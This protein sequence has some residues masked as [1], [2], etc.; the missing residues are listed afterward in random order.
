MSKHLRGNGLVA[1][2]LLIAFMAE[3]LA[4]RG[5][6]YIDLNSLPVPKSVQLTNRIVSL[7][8]VLGCYLSDDDLAPL[9]DVL[10]NEYQMLAG[11][12]ATVVETPA[13]AA[14]I[15]EIDPSLAEQEYRLELA[16]PVRI[17]GG[18]YLGVAM[19]SVTLMQSL[20]SD[21]DESRIPEGLV[22]DKPDVPF[23]GL[24]IDPARNYH[25]VRILKQLVLL[26]RW[27][28][29]NFLQL[30]LTDDSAFTFPTD[31]FSQ[32]STEGHRYTKEELFDLVGFAQRQG[33]TIIPELEVPGHAGQLVARLPKTFGHAE[34]ARNPHTINMGRESA[35]AAIDRIIEELAD[36]FHTS[37]YIHVGGDE[38]RLDHLQNWPAPE[39]QSRDCYGLTL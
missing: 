4:A 15:L 24:L 27:Y 28:R 38:A 37:P 30:H 10:D 29:I 13:S 8:K 17:T 2:L 31:S 39:W 9:V 36:V 25:D 33:V 19:G 1:S 20:R 7:P 21:S 14:I 3:L 18:S 22:R 35:Y 23:R 6:T 32:L 34:T 16:R 11:G 12:K 5:L 26:C